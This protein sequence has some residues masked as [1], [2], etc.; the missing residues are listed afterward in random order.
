VSEL[1]FD[2][3]VA[4]VTG[5]AGG[6]GLAHAKLL[7]ARGAHVVVN[8]V[9][10]SV[11]G[12]SA[13]ATR[14]DQAV[15]AIRMA[16]GTAIADTHSVA[17]P[18]GAAALVETALREFGQIDVVIN[19]AGILRDK[20]LT[21]MTFEAVLA[22]HLRGAFLVTQAAFPHLRDRGYGRIVNTT[23][24]AGLYGNFGQA[25]YSAAKA[26]LV[27]LTKT[28][29]I[30]GARHGIL[31]NAVSPGALTRMTGGL[32]GLP[33][34]E[35]SAE[36]L[37]PG[38][39]SPVVLWLAHRDCTVSGEMFGA[40]GGMVTRVVIGETAGIFDPD[41]TPETIGARIADIMATE[42]MSTPR[43]VADTMK[44]LLEHVKGLQ[45]REHPGSD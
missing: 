31:A 33:F 34:G 3:Q 30:E 37:S 29:A 38:K 24:P 8:D 41:L 7:A 17:T 5:S 26:G 10:S 9:G 23:S 2:G 45:G 15:A 40:I 36:V 14:A 21:K 22:V 42:N 4:V 20:S 44:P 43:G 32:E 18:E 11:R 39:V 25:N 6:L 35:A 28:V 19:N 16:G 1:R 12:E 13:D 27:G